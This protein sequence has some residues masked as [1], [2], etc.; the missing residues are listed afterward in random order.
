M[1]RG[2]SVTLTASRRNGKLPSCEPCR[3]AKIACDHL[4]PV[5]GRCLKRGDTAACVYHPAPMTRA[6]TTDAITTSPLASRGSSHGAS[7]NTHRPEPARTD[8][9]ENASPQDQYYGNTSIAA[10]LKDVLAQGRPALVAPVDLLEPSRT[11]SENV[12]AGVRMLRQA[13]DL[14]VFSRLVERWF[15]LRQG[16]VIMPSI[17]RQ[18]AT[19]LNHKLEQLLG[20]SPDDEMF[21]SAS[22]TI[23]QNA[24]HPLF[25]HQQ[26]TV[27]S[28]AGVSCRWE[29]LGI[30]FVLAG[31]SANSL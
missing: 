11:S 2:A 18:L 25:T 22:Q 3:K 4:T 15:R 27:A 28:F 29:T 31:L 9:E 24:R 14:H 16:L 21:T 17:V 5:C 12:G 30:V 26:V 10:A 7:T 8:R 19:S 1:T 23:F 13:D 20:P 6:R